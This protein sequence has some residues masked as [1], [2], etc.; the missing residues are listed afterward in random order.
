MDKVKDLRSKDIKI[1][2]GKKTYWLRFDLLAITLIEDEYDDI[3]TG[4]NHL[5]KQDKLKPI[6]FILWSM[7]REKDDENEF[8]ET[9]I[10]LNKF[11][12][13]LNVVAVEEIIEKINAAI[14]A[15]TPEKVRGKKK[16]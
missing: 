9:G 1:K 10:E 8:V 12:T 15:S 11:L 14:K 13:R 5:A 7:L 4:L 6:Y 3:N 2:I 16:T